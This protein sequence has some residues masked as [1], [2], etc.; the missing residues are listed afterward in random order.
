M[1]AAE[2]VEDNKDE[3][4]DG[5]DGNEDSG[6]GDKDDKCEYECRRGCQRRMTTEDK[7]KERR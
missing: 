7:D 4:G 2:G 5:N 1:N 6:E 3:D